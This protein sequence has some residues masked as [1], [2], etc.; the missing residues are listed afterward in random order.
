MQKI[1]IQDINFELLTKLSKQGSKSTIY[2]NNK[3]C[4]K[5]LDKLKKEEKASLYEKLI[6]MNDLKINNVILPETLIMDNDQLIGYIMEYFENSLTLNNKYIK[7]RFVNCQNIFTDVINASKILKE[8]HKENIL[9]QDLSFDNILVNKDGI[10]KFC[11]LDGCCYN[12]YNSPFISLLLKRFLIDYRKENIYLNKNLDKLSMI[13]SFYYLLY[14]KEIQKLSNKKYKS[15]SNN[16]NTLEILAPTIKDLLDRNKSLI[17]L[18][19][20]DEIIDQ[21]DNYIIDRNTQF[22]KLEKVLLKLF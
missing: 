19:Y 17:E 22:N 2:K 10:I 16:I 11:D 20:L 5:I 3:D 7:Y 14:L 1:K 21:S 4:I 18:P 15:L 8:I 9:C 6:A 12:E 13:L